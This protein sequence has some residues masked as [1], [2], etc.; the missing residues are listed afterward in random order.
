[1]ISTEESPEKHS[2][3]ECGSDIVQYFEEKYSGLRG[4][5]LVCKIDFPLE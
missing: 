3:W 5:C 4:K 2:C 1:M